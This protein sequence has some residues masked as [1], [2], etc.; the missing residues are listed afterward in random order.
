MRPLIFC[1]LFGFIM[2]R[3]S[4]FQ[5]NIFILIACVASRMYTS[6]Y[7]VEDID[8]L[9][10]A[11]ALQDYSIVN[12][13]PHFPGYPVFCFF[14]KILFIITNSLG[15]T[16]SIIGGLSIYI[17]IHFT[18]RLARIEI[19]TA[20]GLLCS[21]VIFFNPLLWIMS[22]RYMPDMFGAA[23]AMTAIYFLVRKKDDWR[24]AMLGFFLVGILAGS[25]LSYLPLMVVPIYFVITRNENK[26]SLLFSFILGSAIWLIPLIWLTGFGDL[27]S[28]AT[29]QTVG[30]FTDFGGTSITENNWSIRL[31]KFFRSIWADGFGGYWEG[32]SWQ[33]LILS[34]PMSLII[35]S[36]IKDFINRFKSDR[37]IRLM[38]FSLLVYSIWIL[39]FQNVIHKSRH[40]IPIIMV[41]HFFII[42]AQKFQFWKNISSRVISILFIIFTISVTSVLTHQHQSPS[43]VS[44]LKDD[45]IESNSFDTIISIPLIEY[46]LRSHGVKANYL[47]FEDLEEIGSLVDIEKTLIVGN[48]QR[49]FK[50]KYAVVSK[51]KYYHNPYVNRMWPKIETF[52]LKK[53]GHES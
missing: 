27:L 42:S 10:F 47:H 9:R 51:D 35:F 31:L 46:Y 49:V 34:I 43:A 37:I 16:F 25:R 12:L 28:A 5:Y 1:L 20:L 38:V 19:S 52:V 53:S 11:L 2:D 48:N 36:G 13:Q 7:Y 30:H 21:S 8:S 45:L 33:T 22:N 44:K 14:A 18:L 4:T 24:G 15:A 41:L 39:M 29:K 32:R 40:V 3:L 6:I 17:I 26:T 23:I 50:K